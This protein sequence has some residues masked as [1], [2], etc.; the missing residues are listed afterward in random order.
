MRASLRL[1]WFSCVLVLCAGCAIFGGKEGDTPPPQ[2]PYVPTLGRARSEAYQLVRDI[3]EREKGEGSKRC[4]P[5]RDAY[6]R[7][8]A[9][10]D[11]L[12]EQTAA[13]TKAAAKPDSVLYKALG[14]SLSA[15]ETRLVAAH[16]EF[17]GAEHMSEAVKLFLAKIGKDVLL[18]IAK[19]GPFNPAHPDSAAIDKWVES[20]RWVDF[21]RV[22]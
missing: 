5:C 6:R 13:D 7:A 3:R 16:D 21:D 8:K 15:S 22:K 20:M 2:N 18:E 1:I 14:D 11:V 17:M 10:S 19:S 12:I 9:D 4:V